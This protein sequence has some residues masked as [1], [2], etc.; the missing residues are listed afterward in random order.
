M[1]WKAAFALVACAAALVA[2]TPPVTILEVA[3]DNVV[4]YHH[5]A[6]DPSKFASSP[7]RTSLTLTQQV[8]R[9][10]GGVGDIVAVNGKPV[11][12]V[13]AYRSLNTLA[14]ADFTPGRPIADRG[15]NCMVDEHFLL[16]SPDGTEIGTIM[17][18]GLGTGVAPPGSPS[19]ATSNN[20][21]VVGGTGAF[22]GVRGQMSHSGSANV[23][24]ASMMEDPAYRRINGGGTRRV[25]MHLI[26]MTWPE[27]LTVPTG[28]AIFHGDDFSPVTAEK[29]ARAGERLVMSVSGLG[30]VRPKLDPG[31]PFRAWEAG[32]EHVV[33]SPVDVTA[34]HSRNQSPAGGSVGR[35]S[36]FASWFSNQLWAAPGARGR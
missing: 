2:Q 23:R 34:R 12:G 22:L 30:P 13:W 10:R 31:K 25:V 11:K 21:A 17:T 3:T 14:A 15:G 26:P 5:D 9:T 7:A 20:M 16:L 27:V 1:N 8:F 29:P 28:P 36:R 32:Q 18:T 35:T 33:N 24:H 19:A 6:G 4:F